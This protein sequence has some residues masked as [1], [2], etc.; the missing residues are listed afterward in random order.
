MGYKFKWNHTE[1]EKEV[2]KESRQRLS[3]S[4]KLIRD[5]ARSKVRVSSDAH[6]FRGKVYIPG[7]LK[8]SIRYKLINTGEGFKDEFKARIGVDTVYG[9]FQE[10]GPV[11]STRTI[12]LRNL[13]K[14][15][16]AG[17][18]TRNRMV[19][20][21]REQRNTWKFTP[22]LRPS[23]HE[24]EGDIKNIMGV[25]TNILGRA[26]GRKRYYEYR[27]ISEGVWQ[28]TV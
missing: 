25:G 22:F 21:S 24:K 10:L 15:E 14:V 8:K 7:S 13:P 3:D 17:A 5:A 18:R 4:A 12:K 11:N 23:F 20:Q 19:Y 1:L 16:K 27:Q 28:K 26:T 6:V 9:V 2:I